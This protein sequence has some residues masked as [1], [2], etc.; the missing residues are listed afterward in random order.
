[1]ACEKNSYYW[2]NREQEKAKRLE[3][4]YKNRFE[5]LDKLK[6]KNATPKAKR[7]Y[8]IANWKRIGIVSEDYD[9]LYND[10]LVT[11]KC[12]NC[13]CNFGVKGDKSGRFRT[14]HHDHETGEP[15]MIV[16]QPCNIRFR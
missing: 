1:M 13:Q 10:Y 16:C 15:L 11:E 4:Y 2:R 12:Q 3:Y 8:T 5:I 9:T 7:Y 14:L 6:V